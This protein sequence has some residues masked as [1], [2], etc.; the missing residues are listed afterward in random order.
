MAQWDAGEKVIRDLHCAIGGGQTR[1]YSPSMTR[2]PTEEL[3]VVPSG[4][5]VIAPN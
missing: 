3:I 5:E 4:N 1:A 2:K